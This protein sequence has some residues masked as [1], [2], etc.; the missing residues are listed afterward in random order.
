VDFVL[1]SIATAIGGACGLIYCYFK[2]E[3]RII[4]SKKLKKKF[5]SI[6]ERCKSCG[7]DKYIGEPCDYCGFFAE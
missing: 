3:R 6:L 4:M 5:K 7:A 2:Y 1:T